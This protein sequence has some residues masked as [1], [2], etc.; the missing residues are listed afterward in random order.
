MSSRNTPLHIA[1]LSVPPLPNGT[2]FPEK[3][4]DTTSLHV[5]PIRDVFAMLSAPSRCSGGTHLRDVPRYDWP[6]DVRNP[7]HKDLP[8]LHSA[9]SATSL[10]VSNTTRLGISGHSHRSVE[11]QVKIAV[12]GESYHTAGTPRLTRMPRSSPSFLVFLVISYPTPFCIN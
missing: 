2:A 1:K 5:I 4:H 3:A 8:F 7:Q 6:I 11:F 9:H 12:H 10:R